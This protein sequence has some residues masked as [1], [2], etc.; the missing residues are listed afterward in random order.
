MESN[1][2]RFLSDR[3]GK[4][5]VAQR[6]NIPIIG[7]LVLFVAANIVSVGPVAEVLSFF[8]A[9]FLFTWAYLELA[10]GSSPFRRVLGAAVLLYLLI[11]RLLEAMGSVTGSA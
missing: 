8:S 6:P 4:I 2:R 3:D 1:I 9:A 7:W 10:Q 11:S 5:T